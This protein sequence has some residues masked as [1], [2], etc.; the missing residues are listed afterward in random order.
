MTH[1]LST[2]TLNLVD[3]L[4]QLFS[5]ASCQHCEWLQWLTW[6][7]AGAV[8]H[9]P[10]P[11]TSTVTAAGSQQRSSA[12]APWQHDPA[13]LISM[14][15]S[16]PTHTAEEEE[17]CHRLGLLTAP[18]VNN[19]VPTHGHMTRDQTARNVD[20]TQHSHQVDVLDYTERQKKDSSGT[21]LCICCHLSQVETAWN[22]ITSEGQRQQFVSNGWNKYKAT[23]LWCI[24][25]RP[26]QLTELSCHEALEPVTTAAWDFYR[27]HW[28]TKRL[29]N[30][31][32]R[33]N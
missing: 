7:Q 26:L 12:A 22:T 8:R 1:Y 19:I 10:P 4:V 28:S 25:S 6:W 13:E 15:M 16:W 17:I 27:R 9:W 18:S 29:F 20:D 5:S 21:T 11:L 14:L 24:W 3:S 32:G 23:F 30:E 33:R 2:A 31:E